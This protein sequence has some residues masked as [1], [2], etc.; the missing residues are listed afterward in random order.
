MN[1]LDALGVAPD[2]VA[3]NK[4]T[5]SSKGQVVLPRLVRS[6]LHLAPGTRFLC[7]IRGDSVVLTPEHPVHPVREHVT[8]SLTGLRVTKAYPNAEPVT[9]DMIQ[10]LLEDYP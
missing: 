2:A 8:D 9:S 1:L 7:E 6:R 10:E 4:T 3:M 5:L